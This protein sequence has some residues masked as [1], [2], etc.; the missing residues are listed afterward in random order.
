MAKKTFELVSEGYAQG[1]I[2][3]LQLLTAQRTYSQINLTYL[4]NL[5]KL[6]QQNVEIKGMLLKGSLE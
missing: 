6:W 5:R 2:D 3:F 1:E 4:E